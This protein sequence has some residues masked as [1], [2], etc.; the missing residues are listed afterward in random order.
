[1]LYTNNKLCAVKLYEN[2]RMFCCVW[3]VNILLLKKTSRDGHLFEI[4]ELKLEFN[5]FG[6]NLN[7]LKL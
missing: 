4:S 3:K 6:F 7:S 2:D 5:N 1:M